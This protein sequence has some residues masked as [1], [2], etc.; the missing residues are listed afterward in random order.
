MGAGAMRAGGAEY[1]L[2]TESLSK[3]GWLK[4]M[5]RPGG[6]GGKLPLL[7]ADRMD[8]ELL[9]LWEDVYTSSK[10]GAGADA[11]EILNML[12]VDGG[13][14]EATCTGNPPKPE[15]AVDP[16]GI[17][18]FKFPVVPVGDVTPD[19]PKTEPLDGPASMANPLTPPGRV[20][21]SSG[22][23]LAKSL[24]RGC[25]EIPLAVATSLSLLTT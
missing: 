19:V 6:R 7:G 2:Y 21:K 4:L 25:G 11:P 20:D 22:L 16:G 18:K 23:R 1:P 24:R 15:A 13:S 3:L 8:K 10:V 9:L 12:S 14:L 5:E 17:S